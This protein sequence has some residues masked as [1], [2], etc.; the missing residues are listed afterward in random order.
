MV[1]STYRWMIED[2]TDVAYRLSALDVDWNG[3]HLLSDLSWL[4]VDGRHDDNRLSSC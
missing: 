3:G 4:F 1:P 2:R